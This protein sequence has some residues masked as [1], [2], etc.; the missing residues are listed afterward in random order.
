MLLVPLWL[1]ARWLLSAVAIPPRCRGAAVRWLFARCIALPE[2]YHGLD[3]ACGRAFEHILTCEFR[4][5]PTLVPV[6]AE[7]SDFCSG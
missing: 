3:K 7:S 5:F 6:G 4:H 2:L 1:L